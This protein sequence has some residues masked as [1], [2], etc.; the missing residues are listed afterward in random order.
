M[1]L[2]RAFCGQEHL[3]GWGLLRLSIQPVQ[4]LIPLSEGFFFLFLLSSLNYLNSFCSSFQLLRFIFL[5]KPLRRI[6]LPLLHST[7]PKDCKQNPSPFTLASWTNQVPSASIYFYT[8]HICVCIHTYVLQSHN[9]L[10]GFLMD[11]FQFLTPVGTKQD[12]VLQV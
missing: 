10:G 5:C 4:C 9:H 12:I 2:F 3:Q 6:L 8:H 1:R 11:S 7:P